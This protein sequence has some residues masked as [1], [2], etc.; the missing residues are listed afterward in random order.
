MNLKWIRLYIYFL[1]I[2]PFFLF[3]QNIQITQIT[4]DV[5]ILHPKDVRNLEVVREVGGNITAVRTDS[6]IIV[7]DS[8]ISPKAGKEARQ[9]I[10]E[11]F[12]GIPIKYLIN[13]H[14]H[15]DHI[16]GNQNFNDA[17][18]IGHKNLKKYIMDDYNHLQNKYGHFNKKITELNIKI[19]NE[20]DTNEIEKNRTDMKYWQE[21]KE[22]M[23]NFSPTP[24]TIQITSD[25]TINL[26]NKTFEILYFGIAHTNN[27]LVILDKEDRT[28]IMNDLLCYKK[29]YIMKPESSAK[30][31]IALLNKLIERCDE[32][33]YV[34][35]GHGGVVLGIEAL[36]EQ[37]NYLQNICDVVKEAQHG[38]K[39]L[40]QAKNEILLEQY[41]GYM[42]YDRIGLDIEACWGQ[43][44][45]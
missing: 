23:E 28:L 32:Y 7:V 35:P 16:R 1:I 34:I 18:I 12:P 19:Q 40:D 31:W 6:G 27:D 30:N 14:H 43:L 33:E 15:A 20:P 38:K 45:N 21:V 22:F 36:K 39:T 26:G 8:F 5:I 41:N 17:E 42:D 29:C 13:S 4:N 25:T 44:E 24:P 3:S 9:L 2:A 10:E 11:H 37:R